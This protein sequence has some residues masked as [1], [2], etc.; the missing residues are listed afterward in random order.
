VRNELE[1]P[2]LSAL[3]FFRNRRTGRAVKNL[4]GALNADRVG[5]TLSGGREVKM[6]ISA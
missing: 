4:A 3:G 2:Q 1:M 6:G 5:C